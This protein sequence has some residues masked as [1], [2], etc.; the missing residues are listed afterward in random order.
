MA[1]KLP[2]VMEAHVTTLIRSNTVSSGLSSGLSADKSSGFIYP[3]WLRTPELPFEHVEDGGHWS[4][5][6]P[7]KK[8][9]KPSTLY[10]NMLY[11]N[12]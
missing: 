10:A 4:R 5:L 12:M 2:L 6:R 9:R 1:F 3:D 7:G 11:P 8:V